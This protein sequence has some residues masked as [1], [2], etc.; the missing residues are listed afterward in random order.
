MQGGGAHSQHISGYYYVKKECM[1]VE[2]PY[3]LALLRGIQSP[4]RRLVPMHLQSLLC[5]SNLG[6]QFSFTPSYYTFPNSTSTKRATLIIS[7]KLNIPLR[8]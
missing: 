6:E 3:I 2:R 1:Y 5:I 8:Y 7:T 4:E